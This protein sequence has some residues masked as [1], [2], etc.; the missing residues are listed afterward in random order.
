MTKQTL[1]S[2][3]IAVV[4]VFLVAAEPAYAVGGLDKITSFMNDILMLLRGIS[5]T[6]V[7][8]AFIWAGYKF[9]FQHADIMECAKILGGGILIGSSTE[10]AQFFLT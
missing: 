1:T 10:L 3:A 6:V 9:L 4:A 5:V 8:I 2:I 7:A